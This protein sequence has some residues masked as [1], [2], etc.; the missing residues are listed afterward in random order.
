MGATDGDWRHRG[1]EQYLTGARLTLKHYQALSGQW[2][3][4][5]C[6]FCWH[7]FLDPH[8]ADSHRDTLADD[9]DR[10]SSGG[11]TNLGAEDKPAGKWWI[12]K[13]CFEDFAAEFQWQVV[14][15]DP[16]AWPYEGPEPN[17][18][19]TAAEYTRP[20]GGWLPRPE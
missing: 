10:H 20:D 6:E 12:C 4:E 19:P 7:K 15:T 11:Y 1:Q 9:P 3:H 8:Y 18:R 13:Q 17:P 16:D 2:E 14:K 5:H